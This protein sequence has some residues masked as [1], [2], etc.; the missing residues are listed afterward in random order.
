MSKIEL[1]K[2]VDIAI[3]GGTG[4]YDSG[5]LQDAK[6]I[7]IATPYGAPSDAI[8][9]GFYQGTK[10]AF[11]PRH[12][13]IHYLPPHKIPYRANIWA[14]KQLGVTRILAP[15]AVG[16]LKKKYLQAIW[17]SLISLSILPRAVIILFMMVDRFTIRLLPIRFVLN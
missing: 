3:I 7:K 17:L 2:D 11:L 16:S 4:V 10:I 13:A 1:K 9:V 12:G 15:S 8:T 5:L 6:Q 14:L